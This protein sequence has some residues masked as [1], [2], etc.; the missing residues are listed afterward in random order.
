MF[1]FGFRMGK[2]ISI[3]FAIIYM[4]A[5]THL[6]E[7]LK[8]P[9]L[10]DH[11]LEHEEGF[12]EFMVHHYGGHEKDDDWDKDMQLPFMTDSALMIFA[13]NIPV[14]KFSLVP[15][16]ASQVFDKKLLWDDSNFS[17]NYLSDVFQP[18]QTC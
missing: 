4:L 16:C 14:C 18:P 11:Y 12:V 10:V 17:S 6:V 7:V 15:E 5:T 3:F 13:F 8:L 2:G 9:I 1:T